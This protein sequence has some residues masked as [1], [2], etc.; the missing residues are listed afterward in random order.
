MTTDQKVARFISAQ[1]RRMN[2]RR[3]IGRAAGATAGAIAAVTIRPDGGLESSFAHSGYP[4]YPPCGYVCTGCASNG[5]CPSNYTT[6]TSASAGGS[7][8]GCCPYST[9]Y[10][11]SGPAGG[12]QHRCRDCKYYLGPWGCPSCFALCGCRSTTH[13]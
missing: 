12:D 7:L 10:W 4:C 1:T 8:R 2:R 13:Y 5:D 6:C 9:G 3:F 11:Y